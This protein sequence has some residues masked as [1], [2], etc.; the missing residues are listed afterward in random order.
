MT[1]TLETLAT[2][3]METQN[4]WTATALAAIPAASTQQDE[5]EPDQDHE[6]DHEQAEHY[7]HKFGLCNQCGNGL[8]DESEFM[9]TGSADGETQIVCVDCCLYLAWI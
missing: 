1:T 4:Y 3:A 6:Q 5:Y 9:L 2:L 8:D 7:K